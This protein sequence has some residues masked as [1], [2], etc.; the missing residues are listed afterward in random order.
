M[1]LDLIG[2]LFNHLRAES[3]TE[4]GAGNMMDLRK[5]L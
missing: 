4:I 5:A 3:G 1:K 2:T